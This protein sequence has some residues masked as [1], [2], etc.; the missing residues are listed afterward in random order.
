M[1]DSMN[2]EPQVAQFDDEAQLRRVL[3][4]EGARKALLTISSASLRLGSPSSLTFRT[5]LDDG[6][7]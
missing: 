5:C 2:T 1:T 3:A 6:L 4:A 7:R